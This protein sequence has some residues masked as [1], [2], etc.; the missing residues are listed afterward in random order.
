M[1]FSLIYLKKFPLC[2]L[3]HPSSYSLSEPE[4]LSLLTRRNSYLVFGIVSPYKPLMLTKWFSLPSK[5]FDRPHLTN[6]PRIISLSALMIVQTFGTHLEVY[7][8]PK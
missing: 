4:S 3:S 8:D 7:N 2:C 5:L 1:S 6:G